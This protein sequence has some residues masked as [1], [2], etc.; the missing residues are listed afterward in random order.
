MKF[1]EDILKGCQDEFNLDSVDNNPTNK[2]KKLTKNDN[3]SNNGSNNSLKINSLCTKNT[4]KK[5]AK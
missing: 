5:Q 3:N 2:H 4:N 1:I